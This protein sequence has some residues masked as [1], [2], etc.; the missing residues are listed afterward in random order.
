M[1]LP[2]LFLQ[3]KMM[4]NDDFSVEGNHT[5][6]QEK[7]GR[8]T[9]FF[10]TG[11]IISGKV[12]RKGGGRV[13]NFASHSEIAEYLEQVKKLLAEGKYTFVPR[14]K[15]MQSLA[16][17]G[18]TLADAKD[19]I[20]GLAVEDYYKGPKRDFGTLI[21]PVP[22]KSGSSRRILTVYGSISN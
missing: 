14:S 19:T 3:A 22:E 18:L 13:C 12:R 1:A 17:H 9:A 11:K 6:E 10:L 20:F 8:M 2:G 21:E 4:L 7:C 5:P 16:L 15:N